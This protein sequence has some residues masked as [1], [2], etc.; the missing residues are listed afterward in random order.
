MYIIIIIMKLINFSYRYI[1]LCIKLAFKGI[2]YGLIFYAKIT[3]LSA[4]TPIDVVLK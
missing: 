3:Y 4:I 2:G 1:K